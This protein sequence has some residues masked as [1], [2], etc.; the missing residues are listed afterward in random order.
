MSSKTSNRLSAKARTYMQDNPGVNYTQALAAA[1]GELVKPK[2]DFEIV[3]DAADVNPEDHMLHLGVFENGEPLK[4]QV[5]RLLELSHFGRES[6]FH[7][8]IISQ[9]IHLGYHVFLF[10]V[11]EGDPFVGVNNVINIRRRNDTI[12]MASVVERI[13]DARNLRLRSGKNNPPMAVVIDVWAAKKS[14]IMEEIFV[15]MIS[16]ARKS[17]V[18]VALINREASNNGDI[19]RMFYAYKDFPGATIAA[20]DA[21]REEN[22]PVKLYFGGE[23]D[24]DVFH[25]Y[26][27]TN[28]KQVAKK[29]SRIWFKPYPPAYVRVAQVHEDELYAARK[30]FEDHGIVDL[31]VCGWTDI[32]RMEPVK[33]DDSNGPIEENRIYDPEDPSYIARRTG[34]K[35]VPWDVDLT[36]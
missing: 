7:E 19:T 20:I 30:L 34:V 21:G 26:T 6:N 24:S 17:D 23:D 16:A 31:E 3:F 28:S 36:I 5:P 1:R 35:H 27:F 12:A 18:S 25:P 4:T 15:P 2:H 8:G 9:Y 29:F 11:A 10:A 14:E 32:R 22:N 33:L 13:S